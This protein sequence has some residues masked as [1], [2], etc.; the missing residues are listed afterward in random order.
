ML[1]AHNVLILSIFSTTSAF[2]KS[3]DPL[4]KGPIIHTFFSIRLKKPKMI[5]KHLIS[6]FYLWFRFIQRNILLVLVI[7]LPAHFVCKLP[8]IR[9]LQKMN[10][11]PSQRPFL[12]KLDIKIWPNVVGQP[13]VQA[14]CLQSLS[15]RVAIRLRVSQ[16]FRQRFVAIFVATFQSSFKYLDE[17]YHFRRTVVH[18]F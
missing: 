12:L 10:L 14:Q 2:A 1:Q 15:F 9:P 17:H 4:Y 13:I 16:L 8:G 3:K 7:I 11:C 6:L 18:P 5:F